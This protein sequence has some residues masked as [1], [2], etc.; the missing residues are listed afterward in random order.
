MYLK[1]LLLFLTSDYSTHLGEPIRFP[2]GVTPEDVRKRVKHEVRGLIIKH[3]LLPGSILRG[4]KQRCLLT[5][6]AVGL[7]EITFSYP[8]DVSRILSFLSIVFT[9]FSEHG[10]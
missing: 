8:L 2:E 10:V 3:Q 9:K 4:I 7:N 6:C 1:L 5:N